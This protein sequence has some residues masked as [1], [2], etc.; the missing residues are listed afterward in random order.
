MTSI[1]T[2]EVTKAND[3]PANEFL[4]DG[5]EKVADEDKASVEEDDADGTEK[6]VCQC[7]PVKS[8]WIVPLLLKEIM[9]KPN[10]SNAEMKHLVS[11]YVKDKFITNALLQN[12]RTMARD[13]IFGDLATNVLFA[14]GFVQKMKELGVDVKVIMKD[15]QEVLRMLERVV[16]SDQIRKNK[17]EGKLMTKGEK[18]EFIT[19][20]KLTS[21]D[22][23]ED[24][25]L[26]VPKLGTNIL[27]WD[28]FSTSGASKAVPFLQQAFQADACHMNFGKYTLYSCYGTTANCNTYP[29][30][31]GILFGNEDKEGWKV[32]WNFAKWVHPSIDGTRVTIITDQA[33]GLTEL[34]AD[35]LPLTGHFH[36]SFNILQNI[37]KFFKLVSKI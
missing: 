20:W 33:K 4:H 26:G 27:Q 5:E 31:F 28:F 19:K 35:V 37:L 29:V 11:A 8:R 12:A 30:A 36:C 34:I 10:M 13:E 21:K 25:G 16:L 14:N 9:E 18:I 6:A 7:T 32:F 22:V 3:D 1:N 24:G 17:A 2:R 15:R 23:L